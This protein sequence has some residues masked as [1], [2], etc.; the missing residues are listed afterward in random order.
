MGQDAAIEA[1]DRGEHSVAQM[2]QEYE[3]RRNFIV[4]ALNEMGLE[5]RSPRG[6]FYV[7]PKI[8]STGLSSRD[9]CMRLLQEKKVAVVP[10]PAF[11]GGGEGHVRC[12][13]ATSLPQ[14]KIAMQRMAEF[15]GE[16][17]RGN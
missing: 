8:T 13:F 17:K 2:R 5:C 10:G 3:M 6:S 16:L 12:S 15:V 14:I 1:L 4:S 7:F 11:G 9:F